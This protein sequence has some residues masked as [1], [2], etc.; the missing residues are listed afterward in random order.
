MLLEGYGPLI[1]AGTWQTVK[2][3]VLSLSLAFVLGL[4]GAAAKLSK[5]RFSYGLGAVYTTLVRGVPDLVL[6]LLLF[7]SIQIW[8]NEL[9][10]FAG[11][12]QIDIDPF[13]AGVIVLGFIYGAYFTE[14]FRGAFLS[15]PRG[16]LEAGAAFGMTAWQTFSRIMFPQMM[17]F[18]LPGIGNN[19]QVMVK[20]TALVSIIGLA[21][22]VKAT[23][24]AGKG[25]LRF[26]FFML[27]AGAI[28]LAITTISNLVLLWLEKRYSIGVRKAEL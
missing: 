23:Q 25:T 2:L 17:R 19:W 6:M 24:D 3:A 16:Q 22:V 10:D 9:T 1:L 5:N 7:Y 21:D 15:V 11:W 12:E 13:V 27:I 18:A 20:A 28:Y 8:L 4:L 14:T 26:F